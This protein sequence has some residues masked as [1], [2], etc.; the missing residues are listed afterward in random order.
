MVFLSPTYCH[1]G[2]Y[3][4]VTEREIGGGEACHF[5]AAVFKLEYIISPSLSL[6]LMAEDRDEGSIWSYSLR[7][8]KWM[9]AR[10]CSRVIIE[11]QLM[12][13][14]SHWTHPESP[15]DLYTMVWVYFCMCD[16]QSHLIVTKTED[17]WFSEIHSFDI[18]KMLVVHE[19]LY[20]FF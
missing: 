18:L 11:K 14:V 7:W 12:S 16:A 5:H 13:P 20:I 6:V 2:P 17:K 9:E 8:K 15:S 3:D 1:H 4:W 10:C 19:E